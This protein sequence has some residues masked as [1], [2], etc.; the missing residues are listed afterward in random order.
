MGSS[1]PYW[2]AFRAL[3]FRARALPGET[4]LV[5]GATGGV[6]IA[7]VQLARSWGLTVI[8]TGGTDEGRKLVAREGARH[9]LDHR[10]PDYLD[11]LMRLTGGRGVDVVLEM[12]ANVNL[13]K[14]L[15][16]LAPRGRV[17]VIG[18]RGRVEIDPRRAMMLDASILGMS[19]RNAGPEEPAA[20]AAGLAAGFE[21]GTL[22]PVI[23]RELP[24]R[25]SG[26][27][28]RLIIEGP[29]LGKI[30]LVP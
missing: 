20:I 22:T 12:L 29:A 2:T 6:G 18:S 19:L 23:G 15:G 27:A 4:V 24:L 25:S 3:A 17:V 21:G 9:A 8:G 13:D 30:V 7:A 11:Q 5:H 28:H 26:E 10:A 16:V 14:D 1:P